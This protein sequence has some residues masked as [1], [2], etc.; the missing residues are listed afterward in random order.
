MKTIYNLILVIPL[1]MISAM[2]LN[3]TTIHSYLAGGNWHATTT[4]QEGIVPTAADDVVITSGS[5]VLV[6]NTEHECNNLDIE[7][8]ATLQNR[9]NGSRTLLVHGNIT[10]NGTLQNS[11]YHFS[12]NVEGD[13]LNNGTIAIYEFKFTGNNGHNLDCGSGNPIECYYFRAADTTGV[14][15]LASNIEFSGTII[16][17]NDVELEGNLYSI[18]LQDDS[19]VTDATISDF[20]ALGKFIFRSGIIFEG[21]IIIQDT[22][23]KPANNNLTLYVNGNL[24]NNGVITKPNYSFEIYVSGNIVN[25]GTWFCTAIHFHG[26]SLQYISQAAGKTFECSYLYDDDNTSGIE[27]L[28]DLSFLDT[29]ID[30]GGSTLTMPSGPGYTFSLSDGRMIEGTFNF[31]NNSLFMENNA[32]IRNNTTL[33]NLTLEG[34][35]QLLGTVIEFSGEIINNSF[36]RNYQNSNASVTIDGNITNNDT[37]TDPNYTLTINITGNIVN[38]GVWSNMNTNLTGTGTHS[39]F[40]GYGKK[41]SG[42]YFTAVD[43]TGSITSLTDL[44]FEG[45]D[46]NLNGRTL[47]MPSTKGSTMSISDGRIEDGVIDFNNGTLFMENNASIRN[48]TTLTNLTLEGVVQ[49]LGTVIE[50]SGEIINNSFFRNYQNSNVTV[51]VN[52]NITNNDTITDPNYALTINITG[53]IINNGVWSNANTNLTGTGTHS[54]LQGAGSGFSGN[55]FTADAGTG[56]ITSVSDLNFLRTDVDLN[57]GEIVMPDEK[58]L[59]VLGTS[60]NKAHITDGTINGGNYE[61]EGNDYSDFSA[62]AFSGNVT[63]FGNARAYGS[64]ISFTG[65]V[66]VR[67]TLNTRTNVN[68][69]ITIEG[70]IINNG[71]IINSNYHLTLNCKGHLINNGT[72]T[73]YRTTLDGDEDQLIYLIAG[74]EIEGNVRFDAVTGTSP[75]QWYW[76]DAVLNSPDFTDE[77]SQVLN[78]QVPVSNTWNGDF[79]CVSASDTSRTIV[80]RSGIIVDP[81]VILQGPYNGTDMNT[82]LADQGSIPL[83]QPFNVAPWNYAE[84]EVAPSIPTNV[85]DWILVEL[86]QTAGGP[87]TATSGTIVLQR[88]LLLRNDGVAIDPYRFSPELKYDIDVTDNI[89]LVIWHRNH[90]GVM[91]AVSISGISPARYDFTTSASQAYGGTDAEIDMGNGVYGMMGGDADYSQTISEQDISG[92]WE[93]NAGKPCGYETYDFTLDGQI[94]NQDKNQ[95]WAITFETE[96]Q[97]PD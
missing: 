70:R 5:T 32:S 10:N 18:K 60:A 67:D 77:T 11:N 48:N 45:T 66:D 91:S 14:L 28:T 31:N 74:K 69:S 56:I 94:D 42:R 44:T 52:G 89:Y 46:V 39:L 17:L 82:D 73:N 51:A 78:W 92:F 72:W 43:T 38:N 55:Y 7:S 84:D 49:L 8:G 33:T 4:W 75:F 59:S 23:Y 95:T 47:S 29:Q 65:D 41:F 19:Y 71:A 81:K 12:I 86:R 16:D 1:L 13:L 64:N 40:Q 90:L 93:P 3:A 61:F 54:L 79:Y 85:V 83:E 97:V 22:L 88:A 25:N 35:V 80:L 96:T 24:T 30:L 26:T 58:K 34:V 20:T 2:G 63:I 37:I 27:A 21:N 15:S 53:N 50:F 57:G 76:E 9:I 68:S 62:M 36:F 6:Y 87:E